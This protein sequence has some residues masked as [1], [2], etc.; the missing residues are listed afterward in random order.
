MT[1]RRG[2]TLPAAALC[3][4]L[5]GVLASC[6]ARHAEEPPLAFRQ[7]EDA[8]RLGDYERAARG[9]KV[10]VESGE[11]EDLLPPAYYRLAIAEFRQG[12]YGDALKALDG[13]EARFPKRKWFQTYEL[14]GDIERARGNG[15]SAVRWWELGW[16]IADDEQRVTLRRRITSTLERMDAESL[17]A[18]RSVLTTEEFQAYVDARLRASGPGKEPP[19]VAAAARPPVEKRPAVAKPSGRAPS[20][21]AR[22]G[23]LLPLS[24][25]YAPYGQR[26]L[27][28]IKLALGE[29]TDRL[30]LRDSQGQPQ[31]ARAAIDELIAD[32]DV[33]AVIGPLRSQVAETIAPRAERSGMPLVMLSQ[34]DGLTG[35]YVMQPTMT[36]RRQAAELAEYAIGVLK[37]TRFAI[38]YPNDPYG[39]GLS[40]AF[41][42]E[43]E[44]RKGQVIGAL[45]YGT[46]AQEFSL[47]V[48]S[49]RKW[50]DDQGLQAV[51]I[52]DSAGRAVALGS[53][54]RRA[55]PGLTL[56]GSSGWYD[57]A[58]LG[59]SSG[60]ID[61][62]VFVNGF[63]AAS[64]RP[65]TRRFV[66]AYESAYHAT[67]EI[68]EAQGFDAGTLVGRV[69]AAGATTRAEF[70]SVLGGLGPVEG[71]TGSIR[72]SPD[73]IERDL[74]LLQVSGGAVHEVGR[75]LSSPGEP[76]PVVPLA[77]LGGR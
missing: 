21:R 47:E 46:E 11:R 45:G 35:T 37:L 1:R 34:R 77:G 31:L 40:T 39:T 64:G 72:F 12:R 67:P 13:L 49:V 58:E 32:P 33:I 55:R 14:R 9:Y 24:G 41:R 50:V 69:L 17:R 43:V 60:T 19:R 70:P 59:R 56:L 6:T 15:I 52:P 23:C 74:F 73:G 20:G 36:D 3:V 42:E 57:P 18:V 61:G 4:T 68:L 22:I 26:S 2:S 16:D 63:F 62:A 10:F 48:L 28:G 44:R 65:A 76:E 66:A 75:R 54:L 71:A 38:L 53:E 51:F 25:T 27:N 8:F 5:A 29:N 7:A 30:V